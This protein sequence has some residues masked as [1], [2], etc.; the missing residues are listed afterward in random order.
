MAKMFLE[1]F[2]ELAAD[3]QHASA[4]P[5]CPGRDILRPTRTVTAKLGREES[6]TKRAPPTP[7]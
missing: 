3:P 7:A 1:A 2:A 5:T 6:I 4:Y